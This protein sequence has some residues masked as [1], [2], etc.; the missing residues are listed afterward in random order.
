MVLM[1]AKTRI[2]AGLSRP[3]LY[4]IASVMLSANV[5]KQNASNTLPSALWQI[6]QCDEL[7]KTHDRVY[8]TYTATLAAS[9]TE[10]PSH[11]QLSSPWPT[12]MTTALAPTRRLPRTPNIPTHMPCTI[13]QGRNCR[14]LHN[15]PYVYIVFSRVI[16]ASIIDSWYKLSYVL[17]RDL[18]IM[19]D[20]FGR[21]L[22]LKPWTNDIK[23]QLGKRGAAGLEI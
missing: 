12:V 18:W 23:V 17:T 14:F 3:F 6:C 8:S 21:I 20:H 4:K 15:L 5:T 11:D 9:S 13:Q 7:D 16:P 22:V 2:F 10:K 1:Q 19:Q